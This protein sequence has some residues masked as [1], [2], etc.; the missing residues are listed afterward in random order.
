M[1]SKFTGH[2]VKEWVFEN[3]Y[4]RRNYLC[5]FVF[6]VCSSGGKLKFIDRKL[7]KLWGLPR[8][9]AGGKD[10]YGLHICQIFD[11][12]ADKLHVLRL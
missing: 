2:V 4:G 12:I 5:F 7:R 11:V 1:L 10:F 3:I 9:H 6:V 8:A